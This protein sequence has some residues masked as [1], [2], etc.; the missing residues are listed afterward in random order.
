MDPQTLVRRIIEA[1]FFLGAVFLAIFVAPNSPFIVIGICFG[2]FGFIALGKLGRNIWVLF[3]M[4]AGLSGTINLIKGGLTPLQLVCIVLFFYCLYLLKADPTFR[5]RTGPMWFFIPLFCI[6]L[7]LTFNWL[8]GRDLGLNVFGSA[9][10]GG[11]NYM[12]CV[13][14]FIGYIASISIRRPNPKHDMRLPL[15]ILS[16]YLVD[17]FIFVIT[18][19]VPASA[20]AFFRIYD[21]V[22]IEAFQA[23]QV[24]QI[25]EIGSGY[26]T[27][28]GRS[29]HLAYV[30]LACLQAYIPWNSWIRVP[31]LL[32]APFIAFFA[33]ICSLISG[34]RNYLLRFVIVALIGIWQSF[35]L[36]SLFL[37]LPAVSLVAVLVFGQGT[38][39][40]LPPVIQRTLIFLPG[41]WDREIALS[42][43]GTA[44]FRNDLRRVY[45]KEF[46]RADNF[47]GDGYLYDREDLEYSQEEF[48][49][50]M[51]IRA[52]T[53]KD[54]GIRGFIRR[55]MHHE[56]IV[57]I[58]HILGHVGTVVWVI[59]GVLALWK[60]CSFL[61]VQ[62]G[63]MNPTANFGA[64][65][66]V[67]CILTY[68]FLFGCLK[69]MMPELFGFMFCFFVGQ[70]NL[71][72]WKAA[73]RSRVLL[74]KP[75]TSPEESPAPPLH[76]Y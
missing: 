75:A 40:N 72:R 59:F 51:G 47:L 23:T 20:P 1:G 35:G 29:G 30:L 2:L 5:I 10:V 58:H 7:L 26:V 3:P 39:F 64:T 14:P 21:S 49:R 33:V 8:K 11:K 71:L 13:L 61:L 41:N 54:D 63:K 38:M 18:T 22:N 43:E 15:Y 57:D 53:D 32:F 50:R 27:R 46:F 48:W 52:A 74:V 69:E 45:F 55:R 9:R 25:S 67:V 56:G 4:S 44:D 76:S 65:L 17:A 16:G 24:S 36:Y 68:W 6:T 12:N 73:Q 19:L 34:F 37:A 28:F 60:C 31:T 66:I 62:E 42:A 70:E